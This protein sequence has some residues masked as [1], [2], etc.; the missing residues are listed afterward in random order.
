MVTKTKEKILIVEDEKDLVKLIRFNLEKE[1]F[2]VMSARDAETG[3]K[4]ARKSKPDL[5]LLDIMLPKMDGLEFLRTIRS[6]VQVCGER[7]RTLTEVWSVLVPCWR[8]R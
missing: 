4:L 8:P 1:K 5:I 6:E 7:P 2:R 3:L